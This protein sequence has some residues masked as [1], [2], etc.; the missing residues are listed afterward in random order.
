ML[1]RPS[2]INGLTW[3]ACRG[4]AAARGL[5]E[6]V[7]GGGG[8]A[9]HRGPVSHTLFRPAG[10]DCFTWSVC[11]AA[12]AAA[13]GLADRAGGALRV[14]EAGRV[15]CAGRGPEGEYA[16]AGPLDSAQRTSFP[17]LPSPAVRVC[18]VVAVKWQG[19]AL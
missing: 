17:S 16:A 9:G 7:R 14:C 3:S 12:A 5:V 11:G 8:A 10:L 6:R 2:G 19:L 13:R 4:A 1:V 15:L 18:V